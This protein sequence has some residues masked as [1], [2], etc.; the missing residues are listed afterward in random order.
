MI[1]FP[2]TIFYVT[3]STMSKMPWTERL[4]QIRLNFGL[5]A[6]SSRPGAFQATYSDHPYHRLYPVN[7][8][9]V[10]QGNK[11]HLTE[12]RTMLREQKR[13][14]GKNERALVPSDSEVSRIYKVPMF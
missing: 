1:V 7:C 8:S 6:L 10:F 13:H 9:A 3:S 2:L 4:S 5:S 12:I 14:S 11:K